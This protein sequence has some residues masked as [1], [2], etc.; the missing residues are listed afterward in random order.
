MTLL[1]MIADYYL[2]ANPLYDHEVAMLIEISVFHLIIF[3]SL[4]YTDQA[5]QTN[6][7]SNPQVISYIINYSIHSL[8]ILL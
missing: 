6:P 8:L 7:L 3:I 1:S 2:K 4:H 5:I